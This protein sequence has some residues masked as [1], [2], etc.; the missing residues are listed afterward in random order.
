[1]DEQP[2]GTARAR[3]W[4]AMGMVMLALGRSA[5]DALAVLRCCAYGAGNLR[6]F[7]SGP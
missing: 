3:V 1:M 4:Q 2:R 6:G 7:A 5:E